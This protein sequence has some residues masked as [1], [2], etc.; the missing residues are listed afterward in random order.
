MRNSRTV[1]NS[2]PLTKGDRQLSETSSTA[3]ADAERELLAAL[4]DL[5]DL[6]PAAARELAGRIDPAHLVHTDFGD[7]TFRAIV[8]TLKT[9]APSCAGVFTQLRS[10]LGH[11]I[12][13][14]GS[15]VFLRE[16][17]KLHTAN[18]VTAV[19]LN[20]QQHANELARLDARR[21]WHDAL[22]HAEAVADRATVDEM[23]AI[24]AE[25]RAAR[26]AM[27]SAAGRNAYN[28]ATSLI[29]VLDHWAKSERE[30]VVPTLFSP[31]DRRIGGLPVGLTA[32]A[33]QPG[34]GKS[35]LACQLVLGAL[36][37]DPQLRAVWFRGE[38][39]NDLLA[40]K[41]LATWAGLRDDDRLYCGFRDAL[42]RRPQARQ[43]ATDMIGVVG[44]RLTILDP[45]LTPDAIERHVVELKPRLVVVDY[46]Q[47]CE[48]PGMPD[49]RSEVEQV[50]RRLAMLSSKHDIAIIVVSSI[51]GSRTEDSEIGQLA[52][53]TNLLDYSVHTF[54]ALWPKGKEE[55][56]PREFKL[57]VLKSRTAAPGS[58]TL[59]FHGPAQLFRPAEYEMKEFE[60][61]A[62][63]CPALARFAPE[64]RP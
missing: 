60:V 37:H 49:K 39:T 61:Q 43:M 12:E 8:E 34:R 27:Q 13:Y 33:A 63:P 62:G 53:E 51:A 56:E 18:S 44:D 42:D 16:L 21:R 26:E 15:Q 47:L 41:M 10:Q 4:L 30:P 7:A 54:I 29:D 45:P 64:G 58:E 59:W 32:I 36:L 28:P 24:E 20:A 35:A 9:H 46:L 17:L 2:A 50:V 22:A 40:S 3:A 52:K 55:D 25:L 14:E 5:V 48:C 19:K 11:R 23:A 1:P 57:K 38:M 31:I 6:E